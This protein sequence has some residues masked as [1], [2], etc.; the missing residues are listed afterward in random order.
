[1]EPEEAVA[2]LVGWTLPDDVLTG[3]CGE[4]AVY[5]EEEICDS[6]VPDGCRD[7]IPDIW[8]RPRTEAAR[9]TRLQ[10]LIGKFMAMRRR[11]ARNE[12]IVEMEEGINV[13]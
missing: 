3:Y 7:A 2:K 6:P 1:M 13:K 9:K 10:R 4:V 11:L 8:G 12:D 5:G